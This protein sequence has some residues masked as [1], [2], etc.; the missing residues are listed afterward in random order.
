MQMQLYFNIAQI[1]ISIALTVSVLLQLRNS[2]LSS[3]FGGSDTTVYRT[4]RGVDRIL[5]NITIGLSIAF[6]VIT[7]LTVMVS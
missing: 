4:R 2:G 1:I 5:F 3:M 7:I 6:F